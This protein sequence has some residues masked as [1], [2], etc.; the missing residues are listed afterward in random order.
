MDDELRQTLITQAETAF[1]TLMDQV[2]ILLDTAQQFLAL[3]V[4]HTFMDQ[5][6]HRE[7]RTAVFDLGSIP[8]ML[9][10]EITR[11][12]KGESRVLSRQGTELNLLNELY[13]TMET[14]MQFFQRHKLNLTGFSLDKTKTAYFELLRCNRLL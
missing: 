13:T 10:G 2:N 14:L 11:W 4:P 6:A 9:A 7:V 8:P 1:L 5:V 12:K 3:D